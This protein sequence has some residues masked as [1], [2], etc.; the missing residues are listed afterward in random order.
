MGFCEVM[1]MVVFWEVWWLWWIC[2]RELA[3]EVGGGYG[4]RKRDV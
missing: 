1:L 2:G 4:M 3:E